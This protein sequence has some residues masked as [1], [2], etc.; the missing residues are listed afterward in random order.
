M[1]KKAADK[2]QNLSHFLDF[3]NESKTEL[4]AQVEKAFVSMA[5]EN[6]FTLHPRRLRELGAEEYN[7]FITYL[8]SGDASLGGAQGRK[9]A[10]E[11][12][13]QHLL[14]EFGVILRNFCLERAKDR[15]PPMLPLALNTVDEYINDYLNGYIEIREKKIL[16]DQEQLRVALST[17]LE[18][19]R[20]ELFI[21][22]HAI[23]TSINGIMLADLE[24]IITYV[25]PAF[26]E[27]WKIEDEAKVVNTL[28]SAFLGD[29]TNEDIIMILMEQGGWQGEIT[30]RR[31][32]GSSFDLSV[33]ASII[34]DETSHPVGIMA[35]FIDVTE[36]HRLE[37]QFRQA[38]KMEALGQLAGGIVHDFNN[39]LTAI[40]GYAQ[41]ELM[42]LPQD[43]PAYQDFLQIKTATD[44]GKDLTQELRIFTRQASSDRESLNLNSVLNETYKILKRTFPP[45][46]KIEI[47]AEQELQ[48][49][50]ANPSQMSQMLMNLCVNARDA[51][52]SNNDRS[53]SGGRQPGGM[54]ELSTANVELSARLASRFLNVKPGKYICLT[55]RDSGTG[56][57]PQI[58]DRLFEPFFTTKGEKRGTGLGLAVVYGIVQ[59]HDGF[60]DVAS[61]P[62]EGSIFQIYLP[63]FKNHQGKPAPKP[64]MPDLTAG[65]G[66]VLVAED[67]P[68][69]REMVIRAL[70]KSGYSVLS[71][72]DG[73]EAVSL[74]EKYGEEIDLVV[75]DMVMPHMGGQECYRQLK[76]MNPE[77]RIMIMTGYTSDTSAETFFREGNIQVIKKPFELQNFTRSV[78][79]AIAQVKRQSSV[80]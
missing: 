14:M 47:K 22:N 5:F 68:Q 61:K 54:L 63:V 8:Q 64:Y 28:C 69:V 46:V 12:L 42:D 62:G 4:I 66:T 65:R 24:G 58:M 52:M 56:I 33:S 67:E 21:K 6:R 78:R 76:A 23:H 32:D 72:A 59:N 2:Q 19:Q 36:R 37:T 71:A 39:L 27:M 41:L 74:Y 26:L 30:S 15:L 45:E 11:G 20:R 13:G 25:N 10:E 80:S 77:A 7:Q 29:I 49:I 9:R 38:Q 34:R 16:Q 60:I 17:A 48:S 55:I 73:R 50:K 53:R 75:L 3:L 40:S 35:F 79:Q 44:R 18:R 31:S 1:E 51:I 43:S 70:E 57:N